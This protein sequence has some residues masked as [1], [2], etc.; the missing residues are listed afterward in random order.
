MTTW[1]LLFACE[2]LPTPPPTPNCEG[3]QVYH[4]DD[5]NNGLGEPDRSYIGCAPPDGWVTDLDPELPA[6]DDTGAM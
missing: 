6:L 4:P 5:D 1:L 2:L 3:R